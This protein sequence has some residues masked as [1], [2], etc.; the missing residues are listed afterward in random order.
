MLEANE[1]RL[2]GKFPTTQPAVEGARKSPI[3]I[4]ETQMQERDRQ[5]KRRKATK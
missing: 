5:L 2:K 1:L 4:R 3:A